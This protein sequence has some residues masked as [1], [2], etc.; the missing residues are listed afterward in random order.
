MRSEKVNLNIVFNETVRDEV[1][2]A[3]ISATHFIYYATM[4]GKWL[5]ISFD[6]S[7]FRSEKLL[8]IYQNKDYFKRL[9]SLLKDSIQNFFKA[10]LSREFMLQFL[11]SEFY[12]NLVMLIKNFE[13]SNSKIIV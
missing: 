5:P 9:V 12:R 2:S 7:I 11:N 8:V 1:S 13:N 3:L 4:T 10:D 6:A